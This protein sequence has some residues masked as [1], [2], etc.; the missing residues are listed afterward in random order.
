[1]KII[2]YT[3]SPNPDGLTAACGEAAR[4]GAEKA[5]AQV[6]VVDLN[7]TRVG[8]CRA[9]GRGY[10]TCW[11]DHECQVLDDFQNLHH[12]ILQA[13]G[14]VMVSP[15]YWGEM[16]ESAKAFFDRL[17]R[18]E[19]TRWEESGLKGKGA[20]GIA[21]AGGSGRGTI[22]C[23]LSMQ[24]FC[25]HVHAEIFDL[26]TITQKSRR[27]KLDT[28]GRCMAEMVQSEREA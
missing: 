1:M 25:Q 4:L 13:D 3:A 21:A 27:Y 11:S 15:V 6:Q 26:I 28:I 22:T 20:V 19:G 12:E 18:C 5:G 7:K 24:Q 14:F 23:L 2:V 9:C 10:G 17:R 16:S 8:M